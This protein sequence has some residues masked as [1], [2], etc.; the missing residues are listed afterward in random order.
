MKKYL[1]LLVFFP[2]IGLAQS[3]SQCIKII[4]KYE[5]PERIYRLDFDNRFLFWDY[6]MSSDEGYLILEEANDKK[7]KTYLDAVKSIKTAI[8]V[9]SPMIHQYPTL[10]EYEKELQ[11]YL[12]DIFGFGNNTG[13][14]LDRFNI[15]VCQDETRNACAYPN[16]DIVLN[17]G[18]LEELTI[19]ELSA[20]VAH[21]IAHAVL[22]HALQRAY[23]VNR[24]EKRNKVLAGIS[25][26]FQAL[27]AAG[28]GYMDGITGAS[29]E[30]IRQHQQQ[31]STQI[32]QT[33]EWATLDAHGRYRFKYSREQEI[34]SDIL[35][36]RY[37]QIIW[38]DTTSM[39]SM[40]EKLKKYEMGYSDDSD[41]PSMTYRINILKAI[42]AYDLNAKR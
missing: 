31:T 40:L 16:F 38:N 39:I 41:H 10:G 3:Q 32:A 6:L 19:Q 7:K 12:D 20:A 9:Y 29:E 42:A 24:K 15:F 37:L 23:A 30:E 1:L 13:S 25:M 4:K 14:I 17:S 35:A 26:G 18:I 5:I 27:G 36:Y 34:Q 22:H 21:E 2:L 8:S 28:Q 11:M 33:W